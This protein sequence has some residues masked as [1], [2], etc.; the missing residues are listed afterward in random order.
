M[1]IAEACGQ[2]GEVEFRKC[3]QPARAIGVEVEYQLLLA[4]DLQ[5]IEP[6]AHQVLQ[7]QLVEVR[8]MLSGLMKAVPV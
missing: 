6:A 7:D 3:L 4:R 2:D 8:R 1:K 5:F